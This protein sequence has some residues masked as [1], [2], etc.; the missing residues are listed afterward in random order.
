MVWSGVVHARVGV[1]VGV[2]MLCYAMLCCAGIRM[3]SFSK[4]DSENC[5]RKPH[6]ISN[7]L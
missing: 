6:L 5:D 4:A 2:C 3:A 1:D 7:P